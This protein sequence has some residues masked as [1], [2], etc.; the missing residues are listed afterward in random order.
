MMESSPGFPAVVR[1]SRRRS[2]VV[3]ASLGVVIGVVAGWYAG[4]VAGLSLFLLFFVFGVLSYFGLSSEANVSIARGYIFVYPKQM[5][6]GGVELWQEATCKPR[7]MEEEGDAV[8]VRSGGS[9]LR[10]VFDDETQKAAF[11][12]E[13]SGLLKR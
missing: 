5:K 13:V 11:M 3:L 4:W 1:I 7:A 10:I 9:Q 8:L 12:A 2:G 6:T